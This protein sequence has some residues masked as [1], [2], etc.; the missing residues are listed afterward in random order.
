MPARTLRSPRPVSSSRLGRV[1]SV[2]ATVGLAAIVT[3][4]GLSAGTSVK[5]STPGGE[6]GPILAH[7]PRGFHRMPCKALTTE[8]A[9]LCFR[10]TPSTVPTIALFASI[11]RASGLTPDR[12]LLDCP[13]RP[14]SRRTHLS[15]RGCMGHAFAGA[16][17]YVVFITSVVLETKRAAFSTKHRLPP[18]PS[19]TVYQV[20]YYN[21]A[22]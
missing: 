11:I 9:G 20:G 3:G 16:T 17:E 8:P 22:R 14:R 15:V 13:T 6:S 5:E 19:G 1:A 18:Y 21:P 2:I 10:R 4:C 12:P 7:A